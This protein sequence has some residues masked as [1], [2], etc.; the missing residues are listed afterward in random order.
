MKTA[1]TSQ[2]H[3]LDMELLIREQCCTAILCLYP[4]CVVI[5]ALL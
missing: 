2:D 4:T 1:I 3:A 5:L